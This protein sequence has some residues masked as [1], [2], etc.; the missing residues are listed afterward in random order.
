MFV[1]HIQDPRY[2]ER[3]SSDGFFGGY[4]YFKCDK[5]CAVFVSLDKLAAN[6]P[7]Q[8][9]HGSIPQQ[10]RGSAL[11][12]APLPAANP[13]TQVSS[14]A[15]EVGKTERQFLAEQE[16]VLK[17][18]KEA[19]REEAKKKTYPHPSQDQEP[20]RNIG[21]THDS[22]YPPHHGNT[23]PEN[24]QP[25]QPQQHDMRRV[26]SHNQMASRSTG[27]Q[28]YV[29]RETLEYL[30]SQRNDPSNQPPRGHPVYPRV[31]QYHNI[32]EPYP[33]QYNASVESSNPYNLG[34]GA[35]VQVASVNPNDPQHYGVIR[36]TGR[37]AGVDCQVAGIELVSQ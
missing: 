19:K 21:Q 6:P 16:K 29:N 8:V 4:K 24:V 32:G 15:R 7:H 27:G 31:E 26:N 2:L 11:P 5:D 25:P 3:G 13:P 28:D 12:R 10:P 1:S 9:P 18:A 23:R 36:W 22:R 30:R 34:I 35:N 20:H 14:V 17:A 33:H 37:V